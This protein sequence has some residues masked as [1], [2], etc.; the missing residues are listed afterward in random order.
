MAKK[1]RPNHLYECTET[2]TVPCYDRLNE[3]HEK[4]T[5][6][7]NGCVY[8]VNYDGLIE[9]HDGLVT[10]TDDIVEALILHKSDKEIQHW[11]ELREQAA[12]Q[13][14]NGI[15]ADE[16]EMERLRT[17]KDTNYRIRHVVA[18]R[19]I[20]QANTLIRKLIDTE[21]E[22]LQGLKYI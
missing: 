14:L 5:V 12:V 2:M 22:W 15:M 13:A 1:I 3:P 19:A 6:L 8:N 18:E 11:K 17:N 4:T 9:A 7:K 10:I 16:K 21:E 20:S